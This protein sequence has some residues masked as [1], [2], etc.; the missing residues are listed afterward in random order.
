MK[1]ETHSL[2]GIAIKATLISL[3]LPLTGILTLSSTSWF[4]S[5]SFVSSSLWCCP[6]ML[7]SLIFHSDSFQGPFALICAKPQQIPNGRNSYGICAPSPDYPLYWQTPTSHKRVPR[8]QFA[9]VLM[10]MSYY[11]R[12]TESKVNKGNDKGMMHWVRSRGNKGPVSFP[13]PCAWFSLYLA[14]LGMLISYWLSKLVCGLCTTLLYCRVCIEC[15]KKVLSI[16]CTAE[17]KQLAE[18]E[19]QEHL[20]KLSAQT[21]AKAQLKSSV[22]SSL[23]F[24]ELH[25]VLFFWVSHCY[26]PSGCFS[27]LLSTVFEKL[28]HDDAL[29]H[30]PEE[31]CFTRQLEVY[32]NPASE[33][34]T[35]GGDWDSSAV[36]ADVADCELSVF[37]PHPLKC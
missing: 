7:A 3:S 37:L 12:I 29:L 21:R 13:H 15:P 31:M 16:N 18:Q 28:L 19:R 10:V 20:R 27:F 17:Y 5:F 26:K 35:W 25:A 2:K 22:A 36:Y 9:V 24:K 32:L 14:W 1:T 11:S 23:L 6:S 34:G 8:A 4:G 30:L 33:I